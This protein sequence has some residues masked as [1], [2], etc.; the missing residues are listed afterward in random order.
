VTEPVENMLGWIYTV[1]RNKIIDWYRKKRHTHTSIENDL[2]EGSLEHLLSDNELHPEKIFLRK[3]ILE[4]IEACIEELPEKQKKIII[5]QIIEGKTFREISELT[6][7][8]IN[9]LLSRKRYAI[10]AL[11]KRLKEIKEIVDEY[12]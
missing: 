6:G 10:A 4:E 5:L 3:L 8:S 12:E 1:A 2:S 7:E 9:T 11:Q